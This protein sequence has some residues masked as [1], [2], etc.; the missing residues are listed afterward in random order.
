MSPLP[1]SVVATSGTAIPRDNSSSSPRS[2]KL[3]RS[4]YFSFPR[5][6]DI[7]PKGSSA[8]ESR[9]GGGPVSEGAGQGST[10]QPEG[11]PLTRMASG[12]RTGGWED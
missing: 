10:R 12:G 6:I 11:P 1:C 4:V 8:L 2:V 5:G 7:P 3:I 9:S